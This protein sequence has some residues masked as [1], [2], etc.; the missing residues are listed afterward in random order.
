MNAETA[1]HFLNSHD[2][3]AI[4][5]VMICLL[6]GSLFSAAETSVTSLGIM[7][8]RHMAETNPRAAKAFRV[9]LKHPDHV[10]TT[11]LVGTTLVNV[12]AA[13]T[14]T[15]AALRHFGD[16]AVTVATILV[17]LL[18]LLIAEIIPKSIARVHYEAMAMILIVPINAIYRIL[19][20]VVWTLGRFAQA[21]I[22]R[23]GSA[24]PVHANIT[25]EELEFLIKEG[26]K[27]GVLEET[28]TEMLSGV[29]EFDETRAREIMTPRTDIIAIE[30]ECPFEEAVKIVIES[31]HSR[32]PVYEEVI[33][34]IVGIVFA[35]D[36]LRHLSNFKTGS[37]KLPSLS[38]LMRDPLFVPESKLLIE[39]F[40]DLKRTK[41]H[42]AIVIDE[43]GGT[44]GILTMEDAL[45][46]IVGDIQDE[47]DTEEAQIIQV[48]K[49]VYDVAGTVNIDD[50]TNYFN[51][52]E[53]FGNKVE[54]DVDT[55]AGWMTQM[56]GE[57]P[58]IGQT[59]TYDPL[60]I[61]V[62]EV[63]RHRIEKLRVIKML[64]P[65]P[66]DDAND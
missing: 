10:L 7:K 51:L 21:I 13:A 16:Q 29:F 32:L 17:T 25:A 22:H 14:A 24:R 20:P 1:T 36:L 27:A 31:G 45:E 3:N 58:K 35:K 48:D 64:T 12:I 52:D 39:V 40:K 4:S 53:G 61:E 19:Y 8:A 11:I 60:T 54:G 6:I 50:F 41:K 2:I 46:Q 62:S 66:Q 38:T 37:G 26:E 59:I 30:K 57:L 65:P 5:T 42:M 63:T 9:W 33:D 49:G 47:F 15:E 18:V 56:L 44:A 23:L 28:K 43:Y 55:I 34:N